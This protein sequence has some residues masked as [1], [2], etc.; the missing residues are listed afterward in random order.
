M[1][2]S[3]LLEKYGPCA[4]VTGASSGIGAEFARQLAAH[5]FD[6]VITAR[7]KDRLEQLSEALQGEFKI[8]VTIVEL[9]LVEDKCVEQLAEATKHL[10]IGLLIN[11]AGMAISGAFMRK[12][13]AEYEKLIALNV[14]AVTSLARTFGRKMCERNRVYSAS[15]AFVTCLGTALR[16][17]TR[18]FNV[19]VMVLEPGAKRGNMM[20]VD[21]C[22]ETALS[23][24][25]KRGVSTPGFLYQVLKFFGS[26]LPS[27]FRVTGL[28]LR[29]LHESMKSAPILRHFADAQICVTLS[30]SRLCSRRSF[31]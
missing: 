18:P 24:F 25:G 30:G 9:D 21:E 16:E 6:L 4:L 7:R 2:R 5:G 26:L 15:K 22:V 31:M 12:E 10:E 13:V 29:I 11:N 20:L 17:E 19:E 23:A 28:G 1:V 8:H 3:H 14:R 27:S